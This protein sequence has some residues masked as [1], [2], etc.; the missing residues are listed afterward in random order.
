MVGRDADMGDAAVDHA[1]NRR[2]HAPDAGDFPA[3]GIACGRKGVVMPEQL[4]RAVD[5]INVQFMPP[6][7]SLYEWWFNNQLKIACI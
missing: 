5:Q 6:R 3:I 4:V 1:E 2:E 7:T